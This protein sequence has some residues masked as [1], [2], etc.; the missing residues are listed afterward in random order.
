MHLIIQPLRFLPCSNSA[1][2]GNTVMEQAEYHDI[3]A[4]I[5]IE[6]PCIVCYCTPDLLVLQHKVVLM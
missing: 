6:P 2:R 1:M 3:G 5:I 4:Q